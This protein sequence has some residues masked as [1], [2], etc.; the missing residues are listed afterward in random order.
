MKDKMM[1][2]GVIRM[3]CGFLYQSLSRPS[4]LISPCLPFYLSLSYC[5]YHLLHFCLF[6]SRRRSMMASMFGEKR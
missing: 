5:L 4:R 3:I 6:L 2:L 1:E